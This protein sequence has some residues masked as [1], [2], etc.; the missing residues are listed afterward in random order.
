MSYQRRSGSVLVDPG[1]ACSCG[2]PD[3]QV[4]ATTLK[5]GTAGAVRLTQV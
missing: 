2:H 4:R 1:M 5:S 3:S